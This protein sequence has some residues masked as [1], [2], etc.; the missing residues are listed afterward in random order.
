[1]YYIVPVNDNLASSIPGEEKSYTVQLA[2]IWTLS[3]NSEQLQEL[4]TLS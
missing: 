4:N 3:T 1:M 2:A